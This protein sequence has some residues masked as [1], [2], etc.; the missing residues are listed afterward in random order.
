MQPETPR[1]ESR[2]GILELRRYVTH[3]GARDTLIELFERQFIESQE[4][5]GMVPAG[6]FRNLDD[7][8]A[9]VWLRTFPD[10]D[11]RLK[12]LEA[13]YL[14]SA[15]WRE[16]RA[17]ANATMADSDNVLL[18]RPAR[19]ASGI[20]LRGLVRPPVAEGAGAGENSFAGIAIRMVDDSALPGALEAF[21]QKVLPRLAPIAPR[22]GY[23]VT[24]ERP[25][26]FAP[27]P[28]RAETA[29]VVI[30]SCRDAAA[31]TEWGRVFDGGAWEVLRLQPARR[32]LYR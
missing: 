17:A 21:E 28:V 19:R 27:L 30:G 14:K 4:A 6:H 1:P 31:L 2:D 8:D 23:Y 26:N 16:N 20:D 15:A 11:S 3:P 12:S 9:F 29:L 5:C 7:P 22:A 18:L 24:E 25:N 10:M 13:F 32:S